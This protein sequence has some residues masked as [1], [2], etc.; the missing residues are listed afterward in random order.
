[1]R[2]D[3]KLMQIC[4][5][6]RDNYG[7]M[8]KVAKTVGLSVDFI[9]KWM[10]DDKEAL[11]QIEEA[12]RVG[13]M[14]LA[15]VLIDRAV[16]GVEEDV[17]YKG[18]V[19]GTKVN[20]SDTLLVKAVEAYNPEF[21]KGSDSNGGVQVNVQVN[22]MPRANNFAEWLDMKARTLQDRADEKAGIL[23]APTVPEALQGVYVVNSVEDSTPK[24]HW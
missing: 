13:R 21:K 11:E 7:D 19:V 10:R 14:G 16:N 1:M 22:N 12:Q 9:N 8:F 5:E 3:L 15:S 23:P 24:L 17:Y 4:A 6:L 18:E 2:T 20:R